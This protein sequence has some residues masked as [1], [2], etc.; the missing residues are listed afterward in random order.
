[1]LEGQC[2]TVLCE[3]ISPQYT[4]W[5]HPIGCALGDASSRQL[6]AVVLVS[7]FAEVLGDDQAELWMGGHPLFKEIM[8][9]PG[10]PVHY[11]SRESKMLRTV[12]PYWNLSVKIIEARNIAKR[13]LVSESDCYVAIRLPTASA[14][15]H[16][17]TTV[18]NSSNPV[19]NE[20]FH[21]KINSHVKNVLELSL[22]DED[23]LS[24]DDLCSTVFYDLNNLSPG[25]ST[26]RHVFKLNPES[27]EELLVEFSIEESKDPPVEIVTNGVLVA[28]PF[29]RLEVEVDVEKTKR[30]TIP[31][32]KENL[33]LQVSGAFEEEQSV[34]NPLKESTSKS[35][36][37]FHLN[38]DLE[39]ELKI[40]LTKDTVPTSCL[41]LVVSRM[42]HFLQDKDVDL[43]LKA[44][45]SSEDLDVRLSFDLSRQEK[46]F[47]LQRQKLV[48]EAFQKVLHLDSSLESDEVPVVAVVGSGGGV[49]A[50]T[51]LYGSLLGLQMLNLIDTVT[52]IAGV[53]GSTW[54]VACFKVL[55]MSS[56][57]TEPDWSHQ[58][59]QPLIDR[60]Q[61]QIT[62]SQT[63]MFSVPQLLYYCHELKKR[64]KEGQAI[65]L[66]D[67]WGLVIE[68]I[69]H[70]KENEA[71]LSGQQEA[72][73]K[74]QN[75][76][77]IYT[78]VNMKEGFLSNQSVTEWCEFTP[79]EVGFPK[80]GAFIRSEDF[81]GE[82]YMGHLIKKHAESRIPFLL[83]LWSSI[84]ST[85]LA[86][87]WTSLTGSVPHWLQ[88]LTD[89]VLNR[90]N[91]PEQTKVPTVLDT[92]FITPTSIITHFLE[93]VLTDRP[94]ISHSYNF[95]RGFTLHRD[96]SRSNQFTAWK[97]KHLDAF[98]NQLTPTDPKLH[99]VDSGFS[100]NTGFPPLLRPERNVDVILSFNFSWGDQFK[101]LKLTEQ[102]CSDHRLPFP[103]VNLAEVEQQPLKECY[104]F[105][106]ENNPHAPI[107]LHFPMVNAT[108]QTF[109]APGL[110]RLTEQE[111]TDGQV[112]VHSKQ[113]AYRTFDVSYTPEEFT[114]LVTLSCYNVLNNEEALL[115]VLQQA[116]ERKRRA[117]GQPPKPKQFSP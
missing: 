48:S 22:F 116:L 47:L 83:G 59:L 10:A 77:P 65:S 72:I 82:F 105:S 57:Y 62:K 12:A 95:L 101:G 61:A 90:E 17:T 74:G 35:P 75:P 99:L 4:G 98:P 31:E 49:R 9:E 43:K 7:S 113:S 39:T 87:V 23:S 91:A 1:M 109:K 80:Y 115:K 15:N 60:T 14:K 64:S 114:Q 86:Q 26:M 44:R 70:G 79:H 93:E 68:Y 21:Y 112:D 56:L 38:R 2:G 67:L 46:D 28:C 37:T 55:C 13:D 117:R 78:A 25:D 24:R 50:M 106:D 63:H 92:F 40:K 58:N 51:C 16:R 41:C 110:A 33:T 34:F 81:G 36:V 6:G 85:N 102:Y 5:Q 73:A 89:T 97:V 66:I 111:V 108:F 53:S 19:W 76:Y 30:H 32:G 107:V 71:T 69:I 52:Y 104:V 94:V 18:L 29:S 3:Q 103:R 96:Y 84:F 8:S 45:D 20:T 100:I 11:F 42:L 27:K 54:W 88:W